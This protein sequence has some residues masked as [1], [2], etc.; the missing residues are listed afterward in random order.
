MTVTELAALYDQTIEDVW[1][2]ARGSGAGQA[3]A[4]AAVVAAYVALWQDD[5]D[6][7]VRR[8]PR[9][10]LMCHVHQ[11]VRAQVPAA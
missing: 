2:T 8:S 6:E 1:R 9:L 5:D 3:E 10:W 11:A 7:D 4:E